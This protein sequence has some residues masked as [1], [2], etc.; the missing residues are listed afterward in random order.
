MFFSVV[1]P[2]KVIFLK[3]SRLH[4]YTF[5]LLL[6]L[7]LLPTNYGEC[8]QKSSSTRVYRYAPT[9]Q[10][11]TA[12]RTTSRNTVN[13][14][15]KLPSVHDVFEIFS[16]MTANIVFDRIDALRDTTH[17]LKLAVMSSVPL[18]DFKKTSRFG[19]LLSEYIL[20]ELSSSSLQ[21]IEF[22][23]GKGIGLDSLGGEYMLSRDPQNSADL[24]P[25]LDYVV[26]S[27]YSTTGDS[28]IVFGRLVD[29]HAGT[30]LSMWE[31][32]FPLT[33]QVTALINQ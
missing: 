18:A 6:V 26:L 7:V 30:I 27:T 15:R 23:L 33:K 8:A 29:I 17:N 31:K 2:R 24:N 28:L 21:V 14:Y 19:R 11:S 10:G 25:E 4:C 32:R 16:V 13:L 12:Y 5:L 1:Y 20:K 3:M 9:R 22:R